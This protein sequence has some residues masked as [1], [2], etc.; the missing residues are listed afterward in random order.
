MTRHTQNL[1]LHFIVT[2]GHKLIATT[3]NLGTDFLIIIIV[4]IVNYN[5]IV[6]LCD[7]L[8]AG[9]RELSLKGILN[10]KLIISPVYNIQISLILRVC[11]Y[12]HYIKGEIS[13]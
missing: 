5:S 10:N 6:T 9:R 2:T 11:L 3:L 4:T 8:G 7:S 12:R 1:V 13:F